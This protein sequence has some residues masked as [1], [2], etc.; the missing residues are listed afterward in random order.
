M[1]QTYEN[2]T[3][4]PSWIR[5]ILRNCTKKFLIKKR[6]IS[7]I[8]KWASYGENWN[9]SKSQRRKVSCLKDKISEKETTEGWLTEQI[10]LKNEKL[11]QM[12][13]ENQELKD[14]LDSARPELDVTA[15]E[16]VSFKLKYLRPSIV[17]QIYESNTRWPSWIR[18]IL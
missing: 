6:S 10:K 18:N 2:D 12:H 7:K 11:R 1:H 16:D 17:R 14:K 13:F 4:W 5:K 15:K 8:K 3:R 9:D